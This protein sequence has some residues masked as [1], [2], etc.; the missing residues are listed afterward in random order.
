MKLRLSCTSYLLPGNPAWK[1]IDSPNQTVFGEY[2]D[3]MQALTAN[4]DED[5]LCS[6]FFLEDLIPKELLFSESLDEISQAETIIDS[7]FDALRVRLNKYPDKYT[8]IAWLGWQPDALLRSARKKV[9]S[10]KVSEYFAD[11]LY[12]KLNE[13]KRLFLIPLD[14]LFGAE[15]FKKCTDSRNFF[16]SRT[17]LSQNGIRLLA[18]SIN[19]LLLR[20]NKPAAK[21][22]VLDCDNTLWGGVIGENGI[23]GIQIGQDGLGSAFSS[24]QMGIKQLAKNGLLLAISSKNEESDVFNVFENH[25]SMVLKKEEILISKIDWRDKSIH[26]QEISKEVGIGL[27]SIVF[28][29]DNPIEREKVKHSLPN[30]IVIDPPEEVVD[31]YDLLR[32]TPHLASF[33]YSNEDLEKYEQYRA[34]SAFNDESRLFGDYNDFLL[35]TSME[36]SVIEITDA[37]IGRAAQL[38]QKTNQLNLRLKRYDEYT[39]SSYLK[40]EDSVGFLVHLKDKFGDHGIVALVLAHSSEN[41]K[42]AFL[43]TFLMSCRVLGRNLEMW[44]FEQLRL[45]LLNNGFEYLEAEYICGERNNPAKELLA[46]NQF[47]FTCS[48]VLDNKKIEKYIVE[49][50]FWNIQNLDIFKNESKN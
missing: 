16:L 48:Q 49:L 43:D 37:T 7:V 33:A 18:T 28:W 27:D 32:E 25:S 22:L 11:F 4:S 20:I 2:C 26:I 6:V 39:I 44:I 31:W 9:L 24:F 47:N 46:D 19:N 21:M 8:F 13:N 42:I 35:N 38:S 17:R 10:V 30:V 12:N 34:K 14:I 29:D 36:P 40:K 3:W 23:A 1:L 50:G 41:S 15:G 5:V 45:R